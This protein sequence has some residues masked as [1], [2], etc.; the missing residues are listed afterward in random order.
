MWRTE[1]GIMENPANTIAELWRRLEVERTAR[2]EAERANRLKDE[3]LLVVSHEL[4]NPLAAVLSWSQFLKCEAIDERFTEGLQ[5]IEHNAE[6]QRRLIDDLLDVGRMMT[7]KIRMDLRPVHLASIIDAAIRSLRPAATTKQVRLESH[8]DAGLPPVLAD[9]ARLEQVFQNLISNAIKFT[10]AGGD[11]K[12]SLRESD[13][14]AVAS[15][16]DTGRGMDSG[17]AG[18]VFD[19]F[20]QADEATTR[21]DG[22]GLGLWIV[23]QIVDV[24][25]GTVT[26]E[27]QGPGRGSTFV[28]SVP[29]LLT[30]LWARGELK[31]A[32][33]SAPHIPVDRTSP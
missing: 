32:S 20:W 9:P 2:A 31:A 29:L 17:F 33:P 27:S 14:A 22:L 5:A 21:R 11:I 12:V 30:A 16:A 18:R 23:K 6:A 24:H 25:R 8:F 4:R 1:D 28:V 3:F 10:P 13:G 19:R 15:I 26:A 7:G